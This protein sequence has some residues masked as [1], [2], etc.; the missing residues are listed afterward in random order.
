MTTRI[1]HIFSSLRS[2]TSRRL[3]LAGLLIAALAGCATTAPVSEPASTLAPTQ[4]YEWTPASASAGV[5]GGNVRTDLESAEIQLPDYVAIRRY[6]D[7]FTIDGRNIQVVV[8]YGWDY[9]KGV[10]VE[11]VRAANDGSVMSK[12]DMP[13]ETLSFT[14]RELELAIALAREDPKLKNLL[15]AKD[16]NFYAGFPYREAKQQGCYRLSRCVH[17]IVSAGNGEQHVAHAIVDLE[18]RKVVLP[19]LDPWREPDPIK[20]LSSK[21]VPASSKQTTKGINP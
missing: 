20:T 4:K 1:N 15:S 2:S 21:S 10:A 14:D 8:E 17:V 11:T 12:T 7:V 18:T 9:R 13:G 6:G 3:A 5:G 19:K 16:L